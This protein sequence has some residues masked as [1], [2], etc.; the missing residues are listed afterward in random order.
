VGLSYAWD[1]IDPP[2]D[3]D[4]GRLLTKTATRVLRMLARRVGDDELDADLAPFTWSRGSPR[5]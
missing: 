5:A 4:V 3:E 2:T 1:R